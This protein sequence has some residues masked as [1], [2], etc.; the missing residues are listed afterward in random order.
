MQNSSNILFR[1]K[2]ADS[3]GLNWIQHHKHKYILIN[4][5]ITWLSLRKEVSCTYCSSQARGGIPAHNTNSLF[6]FFTISKIFTTL[7]FQHQ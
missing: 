5:E 2:Y 7:F 3:D 1:N 6:H 4:K